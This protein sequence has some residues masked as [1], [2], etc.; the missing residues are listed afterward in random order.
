MNT[1]STMLGILSSVLY[2]TFTNRTDV[3]LSIRKVTF[4]YRNNVVKYHRVIITSYCFNE[5]FYGIKKQIRSVF[6]W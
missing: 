2:L 5:Y 6:W 3:N 1:I 4:V